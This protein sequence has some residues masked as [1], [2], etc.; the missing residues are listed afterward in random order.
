MDSVWTK[1][2]E[3]KQ[4]VTASAVSFAKANAKTIAVVLLVV[5][6]ASAWFHQL[7]TNNVLKHQTQTSTTTKTAN[8]QAQARQLRDEVAKVFNVPAN[9]VPTIATVTDVSKLKNQAFF[10]N[11]KNGDKVLMFAQAKEAI[12]F[13]PSDHK[14]IQVAPLNPGSAGAATGGSASNSLTSSGQ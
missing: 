2:P 9:E 4:S 1:P 8:A 14:I 11:A 3:P 13:R 6:L 7:Q 12:L 10:T 5:V